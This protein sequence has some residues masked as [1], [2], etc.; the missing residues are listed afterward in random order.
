HELDEEEPLVTTVGLAGILIERGEHVLNA[1]TLRSALDD[2]AAW[3]Q[4]MPNA[5]AICELAGSQYMGYLSDHSGS[6]GLLTR[7][8]SSAIV[9]T[10]DALMRSMVAGALQAHAKPLPSTR[11]MEHFEQLLEKVLT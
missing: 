2:D 6:K 10:R 5:L 9:P 7:A 11:T 8:E 3:D 1:V 4:V